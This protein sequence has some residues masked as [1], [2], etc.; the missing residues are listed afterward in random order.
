L[1]K[2]PTLENLKA[3]KKFTSSK[4]RVENKDR[5]LNQKKTSIQ[6]IRK[7]DLH[8]L[9]LDEANNKIE[10][11]IDKYFIEGVEKIIIITGK[12]LRSKTIDNPY[13]SKDLNI[14]KNS[15]PDY[16][17]TNLKIKNKIKSISKAKIEDGGEG[18][19]YIF[20]KKFRE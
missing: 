18:A 13:V 3:W 16:I 19:F 5:Y 11:F 9:S 2:K 4:E 1:N 20:L 7:I 12:S 6:K 8:G 10:I 15:V 14:L 17:N